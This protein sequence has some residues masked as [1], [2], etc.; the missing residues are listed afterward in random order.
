MSN[1]GLIAR[2]SELHFRMN[3]FFR[4]DLHLV[5]QGGSFGQSCR[6]GQASGGIHSYPDA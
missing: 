5:T 1:D 6:K 2:P 4:R 3:D